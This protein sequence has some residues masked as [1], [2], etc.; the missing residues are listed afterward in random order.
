MPADPAGGGVIGVP[1]SADARG[2]C[3]GAAVAQLGGTVSAGFGKAASIGALSAPPSWA[4]AAPPSG[5]AS[6]PVTACPNALPDTPAL[7]APELNPIKGASAV[8]GAMPSPVEEMVFQKLELGCNTDQMSLPVEPDPSA[9][10][11]PDGWAAADPGDDARP[12]RVVGIADITCDSVDCSE[13]AAVAPAWVTA[14]DCAARPAGLV[15]CGGPVNSLS[16][17]AIAEDAA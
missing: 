14:A 17:V 12:C 11:S 6:A 10:S 1:P 7:A 9:P 2:P 15:V 8:T 4:T 16:C 3:S 13:P 5:P